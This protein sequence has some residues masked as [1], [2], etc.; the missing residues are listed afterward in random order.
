VGQIEGLVEVWGVTFEKFLVNVEGIS[1][2]EEGTPP[3]FEDPAPRVFDLA[4]ANGPVG[5]GSAAAPATTSTT[6]GHLSTT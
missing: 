4:A 6:S 1:V 2:A 3:A 5:I